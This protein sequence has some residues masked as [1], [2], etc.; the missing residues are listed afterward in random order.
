MLGAIVPLF[1]A[2]VLLIEMLYSMFI[3]SNLIK[4]NHKNQKFV[5]ILTRSNLRDN[6]FKLFQDS[7]IVFLN[8]FN[9]VVFR[10]N[11]FTSSLFIMGLLVHFS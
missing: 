9:M 5:S 3:S 2:V 1:L 8:F 10:V 7:E 11:V 6:F 4:I